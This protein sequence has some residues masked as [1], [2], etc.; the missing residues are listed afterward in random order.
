MGTSYKDHFGCDPEWANDPDAKP[1]ERRFYI[2]RLKKNGII[3]M[4][5]GENTS[6]ERMLELIEMAGGELMGI[7]EVRDYIEYN[8]DR[9]EAHE[10]KFSPHEDGRGFY[11]YDAW[12][13]CFKKNKEWI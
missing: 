1:D 6:R 5:I 4:K 13:P 2:Y 7:D 9:I 8:R 12:A 10:Q 11:K 3:V